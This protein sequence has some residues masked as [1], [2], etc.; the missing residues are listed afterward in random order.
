MTQQLSALGAMVLS[1]PAI[2]VAPPRTRPSSTGLAHIKLRLV[3]S[4]A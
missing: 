3:S 2:E 1:L 4:R